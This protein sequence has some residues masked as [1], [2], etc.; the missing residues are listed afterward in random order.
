MHSPAICVRPS[1]RPPVPRPLYSLALTRAC[2]RACARGSLKICR[3]FPSSFCP[4]SVLL[5]QLSAQSKQRLRLLLPP[6]LARSYA[7]LKSRSLYPSICSPSLLHPTG[8]DISHPKRKCLHLSAFNSI[9]TLYR[10]PTF[11]VVI[12]SVRRRQRVF[13]WELNWLSDDLAFS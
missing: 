1:I 4:L 5:S 6:S 7:F 2:V 10:R 11:M 9:M 3:L 8:I 12:L 13:P